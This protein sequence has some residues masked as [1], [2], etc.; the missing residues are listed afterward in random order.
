M[1]GITARQT[2]RST[3][4]RRNLDEG[5]TELK[6]LPTKHYASAA[7]LALM[8]CLPELPQLS[9]SS[10]ANMAPWITELSIV[11]DEEDD[12][13]LRTEYTATAVVEYSDP[14]GDE[15]ELAYAWMVNGESVGGNQSQ[16]EG[17][18][19]EDGTHYGYFDYGNEVRLEVTPIDAWGEGIPVVTD[20]VTVENSPPTAPGIDFDRIDRC[21]SIQFTLEST[22]VSAPASDSL[23]LQDMLTVEL[24][25]YYET[26]TASPTNKRF[27]FAQAE[28]DHV[29]YQVDILQGELLKL[30]TPS[31]GVVHDLDKGILHDRDWN[32]IMLT[33][34]T[35][36]WNLFLNGALVLTL[37]DTESVD[38]TGKAFWIGTDP[39]G[40]NENLSG[41][42]HLVRVSNIVRETENFTPD[43]DVPIRPDGNTVAMW[44]F[45]PENGEFYQDL[46]GNEN[47]LSVSDLI[48]T[49]RCPNGIADLRC[50]VTA[51]SGDPDGH[52][53]DYFF[54]WS[55]NGSV[56]VS[57][58]EINGLTQE[59]FQE[60]LSEGDT[61]TCQVKAIDILE[62]SSYGDSSEA[63]SKKILITQD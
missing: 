30:L 28:D 12:D 11:S 23:A 13:A 56:F 58:W 43:A 6:M 5:I 59:V 33:R 37:D 21:G 22:D 40:V 29:A 52:E 60:N 14:E 47:T 25:L 4:L 9:D 7:L 63:I 19:D 35:Q 62:D 24:W 54:E 3:P 39:T 55:E 57:A 26:P 36:A 46:S 44:I 34:D 27:L 16:L 53:I 32:H 51:E 42:L 45:S 20:T 31:G 41:D 61:W 17:G 8:A 50:T 48:W 49:D 10:A 15:V 1:A 2:N 18:P 38:T